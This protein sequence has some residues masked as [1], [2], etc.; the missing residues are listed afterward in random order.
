MSTLRYS[1]YMPTDDNHN[2]TLM[3][4]S[5]AARY[6]GLPDWLVRRAINRGVLAAYQPGGTEKSAYY[7]RRDVVDAWFA[8]TQVDPNAE[9]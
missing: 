4:V 5:A 9:S 8:S 7:L 3:T 1:I 6:V 2:D